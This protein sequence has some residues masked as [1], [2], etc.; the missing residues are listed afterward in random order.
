MLSSDGQPVGVFAIFS[1]EPRVT[2]SPD[3]RRELAGYSAMALKDL[4]HQALYLSDPE[5]HSSRTTPLLERDS[6]I[7]VGYRRLKIKSPPAIQIDHTLVPP[8]L[9]YHKVKTPPTGTPQVFVNRS[10]AVLSEHTPPSSSEGSE[11]DTFPG[12]QKGIG[13]NSKQ[14]S[15]NSDLNHVSS[16]GDMITP[17]SEGFRIPTP[18][19]FSAS[20][21]TSLNPLPPNTPVLLSQD[22]SFQSNMDL[23]VENFMSLSDNDCAEQESSP[24]I[25]LSTPKDESNEGKTRVEQSLGP[26]SPS[27]RLNTSSIS[28]MM[29]GESHESSDPMAEAAFSCSFSA[30]SLGYDLIYVVEIKPS[31][32]FMTEKELFAPGGLQKRI[33]VAYGLDRPMELSIDMHIRALRSRGYQAWENHTATYE[34]GEYQAGVLIPLQTESTPYRKRSSGLVFGAFRRPKLVEIGDGVHTPAEDIQRLVDAA[35]A[36]EDILLKQPNSRRSPRKNN[37]ETKSP[38]RYP[39]NKA[40]KLQN[41]LNEMQDRFPNSKAAKEG[42]YSPVSN[43]PAPQERCPASKAA[44]DRKHLL[45]QTPD[46]YPAGEA[47]EVGIYSRANSETVPQ[48]RYPANEAVE[49]GKPSIESGISTTTSYSATQP[50]SPDRK[51]SSKSGKSSKPKKAVEGGKKYSL[52]AGLDRPF[53]A[54]SRFRPF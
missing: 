13:K 38:N 1:K 25:D 6:T 11:N 18:R 43:K 40:V 7:N 51:P 24:L 46:P 15:V 21:L 49:V 4:T 44:K 10:P 54:I 42:R 35:T 12:T 20:D 28:T 16:C 45:D 47:V 39:T 53:H 31:R 8:G 32:P 50:P 30:Q 27:S 19:P 26:P 2:F 14:L 33:L 5:L 3:Q 41:H 52:D 37:N 23:T 9:R 22:D 48:E 17:D 36:L 29:T 34:N